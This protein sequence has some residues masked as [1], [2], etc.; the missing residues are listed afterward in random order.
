MV[1]SQVKH[2]AVH[3]N[4]TKKDTAHHGYVISICW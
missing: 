3:L 2:N 4:D 1:K